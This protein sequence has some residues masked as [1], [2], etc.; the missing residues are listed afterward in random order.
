MCV[1]SACR[2]QRALDSLNWSYRNGCESPSRCWQLN[3][4]LLQ[5]QTIL[6]TDPS[7]QVCYLFTDWVLSSRD[8]IQDLVLKT[9]VP[10]KLSYLLIPG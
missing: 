8:E 10:C 3:L 6:T 2:G 4:D 9:Q 1:P 7:I 5:D